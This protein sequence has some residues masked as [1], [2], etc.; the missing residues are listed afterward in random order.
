MDSTPFDFDPLELDFPALVLQCLEAPAAL[1]ASMPTR[2][3]A[4]WSLN[5]PGHNELAALKGYFQ[6]AFRR[7]KITCAAATTAISEDLV[8]PPSESLPKPDPIEAIRRAEEKAEEQEKRVGMHI[9]STYN[10]WAGIPEAQREHFWRLELAR[11][12]WK[13]QKQIEKLK[14]VEHTLRQQNEHLK[15][16]VQSLSRLQHPRE[17]KIVPPTTIPFDPRLVSYLAE[18]SVV[19]NKGGVGLTLEDRHSDLDTIV[20]RSIERWKNVVVSTRPENHSSQNPQQASRANTGR[21]ETGATVNTTANVS[22]NQVQRQVQDQGQAKPPQPH[23]LQQQR[24]QQQAQQPLPPP[25]H[26]QQQAQHPPPQLQ[27]VHQQ[28]QQELRLPNSPTVSP[29]EQGSAEYDDDDESSDGEADEDADGDS[30]ADADGD[31]EMDDAS[32]YNSTLAAPPTAFPPQQHQ[33]QHL[34]LPQQQHQQTNP[35]GPVR[36]RPSGTQGRF[37]PL[38]SNNPTGRSVTGA[39]NQTL[40]GG[41]NNNMHIMGRSVGVGGNDNMA[42]LGG[43]HPQYLNNA[44]MGGI[45][46]S[47]GGGLGGVGHTMGIMEE[48]SQRMGV[49]GVTPQ[50]G[51]QD[52]MFES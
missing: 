4:S 11:S 24:A 48:V 18:E 44:H 33:Q 2:T 21:P 46:P 5:P 49:G 10:G 14:G 47:Q 12:V 50:G 9:V 35:L 23:P 38:Q 29:A 31:A 41:N 25:Q 16:Q 17:F 3:V 34:P 30:D 52:G 8:Y 26:V 43:V 45:G 27:Q 51:G 1:F 7:W 19:H 6:E 28:A 22:T 36:T 13:K 39:T 15:A 32:A 37:N 20:S 40:H 42:A